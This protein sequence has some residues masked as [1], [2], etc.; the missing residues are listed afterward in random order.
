MIQI[1]PEKYST[2]LCVICMDEKNIAKI[3]KTWKKYKRLN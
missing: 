2:E 3:K 1:V